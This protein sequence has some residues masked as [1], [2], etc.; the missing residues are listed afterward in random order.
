MKRSLVVFM[1]ACLCF[2]GKI[3]AQSQVKYQ[4]LFVYNF[5]RYIEWPSYGS[6]EFVIGVLGKSNIYNELQGIAGGK[7]VGTK[8]IV[9]K[10]FTSADEIS[11]CQILFVS[12][13]VSSS[14]SSFASTMQNKNTLI[15]TERQ[16]LINKGAGINFVLDDGKQKFE[17]SRTALNKSG[18]K[19]DNQ[20]V[21]MAM[22][23]D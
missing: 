22:I 7:R 23:A 9:V 20:L 2:A 21:D 8:S 14:L 18:L 11:S 1:L 16:G 17:L 19:V 10:K 5:T 15:I 13:E 4:A 6:Q 3:T 12:G